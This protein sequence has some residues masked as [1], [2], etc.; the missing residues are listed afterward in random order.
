M[1]PVA[2]KCPTEPHCAQLIPANFTQAFL[3]HIAFV[4]CNASRARS[5]VIVSE[6][7]TPGLA[8]MAPSHTRRFS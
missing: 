7:F 4:G 8:G 3:R 6:G 5:C 1:A 2:S